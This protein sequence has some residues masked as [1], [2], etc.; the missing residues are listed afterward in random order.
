MIELVVGGI[1]TVFAF[2]I[3]KLLISEQRRRDVENQL[4]KNVVESIELKA[5][6][7]LRDSPLRDVIAKDNEDIRNR[8]E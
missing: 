8:K 1:L 7:E 2:L 6:K 3:G 5:E 4:G